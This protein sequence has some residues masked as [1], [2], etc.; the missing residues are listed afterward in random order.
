MLVAGAVL[1]GAGADVEV[2]GTVLEGDGAE[3]AAAARKQHARSAALPGMPP[4]QE[5]LRARTI[6]SEW[7]THIYSALMKMRLVHH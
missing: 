3:V 1:L 5:Q 2:A 4:A 6:S 7:T